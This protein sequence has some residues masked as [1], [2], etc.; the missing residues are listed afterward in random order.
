MKGR[1]TRLTHTYHSVLPIALSMLESTTHWNVQSAWSKAGV[2]TNIV[3]ELKTPSPLESDHDRHANNVSKKRSRARIAFDMGAT[4]CFDDAIPAKYVFLSHGHIDHV[5]ALFSHARAHAVSCGGEAPTYF[6]P[7]QLLPQIEQCRNAMSLIDSFTIARKSDDNK[8]STN[9]VK[10]E[11]RENLLKMKLIP[12]KPGDEFP[13]KGISY[14]SK[15]NF[16]MR[17][18]EVDHAGHA[19][20]GYI[21]GSRTKAAGLKPEYQHLNGAAIRELVK[22]GITIQADPVEKI[23]IA[24]SGDTCARGLMK[25]ECLRSPKDDVL[26]SEDQHLLKSAAY[27]D[28]AFQAEMLICELTFLD[29]SEDETQRRRSEERGHL[30]INDLHDIFASH[31]QLKKHSDARCILFYHLSGRYAPASRALD[32]ICAGLPL[33]IRN[34]CHVAIKSLLSDRE[35]LTNDGL[36]AL[37]ESNG[38]IS[39]EDYLR[40]RENNKSADEVVA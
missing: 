15:T 31:G 23:E 24:Y 12:V 26:D 18:F 4:P 3:L 21:I 9:N 36:A 39:I 6:V 8:Y 20:L 40:W 32:Y 10:S 7:A 1:F 34:S 30:H 14:G 25:K 37:I 11:G 22:S 5:G 17:A 16:F 27:L 38:C 13:L 29:S 28:Q 19:A 33:E 2:G 35:K